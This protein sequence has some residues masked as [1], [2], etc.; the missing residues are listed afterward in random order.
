MNFKV[1]EE[2]LDRISLAKTLTQVS[3]HQIKIIYKL[4][5]KITLIFYWFVKSCVYKDHKTFDDKNTVRREDEEPSIV[6]ASSIM[7]FEN[8][9]PEACTK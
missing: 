5:L 8:C 9:F 3:L 1:I 4:I 6:G 2:Y 7:Y